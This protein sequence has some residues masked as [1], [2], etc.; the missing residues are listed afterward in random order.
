[1]ARVVKSR[2]NKDKAMVVFF[3][4]IGWRGYLPSAA[5]VEKAMGMPPLVQARDGSIFCATDV[6]YGSAR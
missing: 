1:M 6:C 3:N 2:L 4:Q 5:E